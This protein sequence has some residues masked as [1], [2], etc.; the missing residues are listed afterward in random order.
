MCAL[1]GGTQLLADLFLTVQKWLQNMSKLN[2]KEL[3]PL[4]DF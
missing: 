1:C 3:Q 2:L 4:H